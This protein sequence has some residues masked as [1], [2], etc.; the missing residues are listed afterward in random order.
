MVAPSP[1][2]STTSTAEALRGLAMHLSAEDTCTYLLM[3]N[4]DMHACTYL[5]MLNTDMETEHDHPRESQ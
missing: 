4:A 5:L 2:D 1:Q 3:L